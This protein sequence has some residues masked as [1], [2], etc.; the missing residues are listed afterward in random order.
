MVRGK[1]E[2]QHP[3]E[4]KEIPRLIMVEFSSYCCC[5]ANSP[6]LSNLKQPFIMLTDALD[7]KFRQGTMGMACSTVFESKAGK[8]QCL[9][10]A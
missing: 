2:I 8:S 10:L 5:K 1:G 6:K 9:G 3:R 7:L 4:E